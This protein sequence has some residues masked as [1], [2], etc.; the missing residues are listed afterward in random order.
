MTHQ[1]IRRQDVRRP[2]HPM[3]AIL[4]HDSANFP[5]I[6]RFRESLD[7]SLGQQLLSESPVV[8]AK[9]LSMSGIEVEQ[10][11]VR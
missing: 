8:V 10:S 1:H 9:E 11:D 2:H 3:F 6:F 5:H 7:G 4:C